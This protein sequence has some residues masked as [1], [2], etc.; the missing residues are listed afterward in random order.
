MKAPPPSLLIIAAAPPTPRHTPAD[1]AAVYVT[2]DASRR[3]AV[4][5]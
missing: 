4:Y 1:A 5:E 3:V 2:P